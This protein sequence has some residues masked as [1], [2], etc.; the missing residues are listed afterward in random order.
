VRLQH[1]SV[2][3]KWAD[4][5]ALIQAGDVEAQVGGKEANTA[6]LEDLQKIKEDQPDVGIAWRWLVGVAADN[7]SLELSLQ[8]LPCSESIV[9]VFFQLSYQFTKF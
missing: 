4:V 1:N 6:F 2:A 3:S 7:S 8:A 9:E 5:A